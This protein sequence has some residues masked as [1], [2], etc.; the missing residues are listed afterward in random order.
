MNYLNLMN[1]RS[2]ALFFAFSLLFLTFELSGQDDPCS[3]TSLSVGTTCSFSNH[4]NVGATSTTGVAAPGCGNYQGGDVWFAITMPSNGL[5][6]MIEL[7]G[8]GAFDGG[9]AV[10][11][12][13]DCSNLTLVN[14]D[15]NSGGGNDP[16]LRVDDGCLFEHV[17][18]T[19]W[20]R[21]WENG[22]DNNGTFD[23]CTYSVSAP[24]SG[25]AMSCAGNYLAGDACCDAILLSAD[26]LDGYCGRTEGYSDFPDEI[27]NFCANIDNNS[28]LAFIA[29]DTIVEFEIE[30][31]NC[32]R[33]RGIQVQLFG[34]DD[35]VN[36]TPK[37][38]CWNPGT[39]SNTTMTGQN[40]VVGDV[41][42]IHIDGWQK[43]S[44]DYT[45][46][47]ISGV[48]S[49]AVT[50]SDPTI[51]Q[52]QSTQLQAIA[53]G[54][55]PYTYSWSPISGLSDPTIPSPTASPANTTT[56][57]VTII[58]PTG[59][60][61]ES[62]TVTVFPGPPGA[63]MVSGSSSLCENTNGEVYTVNN[64]AASIYNWTVTGGGTIV[65][66]SDGSSVSIDWGTSGG[67]VCVDVS[68]ECGAGPQECMAVSVV[69][70]PDISTTD[71][72][73]Q[74][75]PSTVNL[76]NLPIHNDASAS[77]P[78]SFHP[79]QVAAE[80][81]WPI[82]N[83]P[84]V[85]TTGTYWIRM[86]TG[87]N[88]YDITSVF[89]EIEDVG[90]SVLNPPPV[91]SPNTV[92]LDQVVVFDNGWGPGTQTYYTDSLDAVNEVSAL[93]S[94]VVS[95]GGIY[96]LRFETANGC[97]DVVSIDV[98]IDIQPEISIPVQP[99]ICPGA[100]L[101]LAT[102]SFDETNG[103]NLTVVD[104]YD[105]CTF[106]NLGISSLALTNTVISNTGTYCLRVENALN[107]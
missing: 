94:P 5:H 33:G 48:E 22:N 93:N 21:V 23:I 89:V 2:I 56:Y 30:T 1:G 62:V 32:E 80:A 72:A 9:M 19:F 8:G 68:N 47:L 76:A 27:G 91:C 15:D 13:T 31:S 95:T 37:A 11:S 90:V 34:T 7:E 6:T 60:V 36:F 20:I 71:P 16:S 59:S 75:A 81:G 102:V 67:T 105:N 4:T 106:A 44:C 61:T 58:G 74:C 3:A 53:V 17:G 49:T 88:C 39:S 64:S 103:A 51:C 18:A 43:D 12:G 54:A 107:F 28:W 65:G 40:L 87:A 42:Y 104:Y 57:T 24:V 52:G 66:P 79:D 83:P 38:S 25:G 78:L 99:T 14:C 45:I 85:S 55:G 41:Y 73:V 69:I 84:V 63:S 10:Y 97:F 29:S 82:I 86:Q 26:E 77:G 46:N 101:D 92:D 96:W 35:C 50:V 70:Q 100:T 98:E